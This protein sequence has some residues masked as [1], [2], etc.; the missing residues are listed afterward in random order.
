MGDRCYLQLTLRRE[1][2]DRF[3]LILGDSAGG[4]WWEEDLGAPA[5][6]IVE[7]GI[8]ESDDALRGERNVAAEQGIPFFGNHGSGEDYSGSR[9]ACL[10]GHHTA[11][12]T[13]RDSAVCVQIDRNM[14]VL[15]DLTDVRDYL[16][17]Q[18]SVEGLFGIRSDGIEPFEPALDDGIAGQHYVLHI[19]GDVEP[20]LLGP[21]ITCPDRD[22]V[23]IGLRQS[24]GMGDGIYRLDI[25]AGMYPIVYPY[26]AYD[27]DQGGCDVCLKG[28]IHSHG[29]RVAA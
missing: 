4:V 17:T 28:A 19:I 21:Y 12:L 5:P 1:D 8:C 18:R 9:F 25:A 22:R 27:L 11:V 23:A 7:I 2:L 14:R 10:A 15:S 24:G 3:G 6:G 20:R 13:D 29:C 26:G 16:D